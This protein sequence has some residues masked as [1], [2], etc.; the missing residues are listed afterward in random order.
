MI[1]VGRRLTRGLRRI[2]RRGLGLVGKASKLMG[3]ITKPLQKVVGPLIDKLPLPE[4]AK[5][6]AKNVLSNPMSLMAG[7]PLGLAGSV[8]GAAG[9]ASSLAGVAQTFAGSVAGG[10]P[11][12]LANLAEMVAHQRAQIG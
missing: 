4:F 5:S 10:N 8:V 2:A 3:K 7:G 12:G 11:A 9:S 1:R 6:I